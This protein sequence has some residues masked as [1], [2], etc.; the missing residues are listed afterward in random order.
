MLEWF[1]RQARVFQILLLFIPF[2]NWIIEICV[3]WSKFVETKSF[4]HFFM[5][6]LVT[7]PSGIAI[8]MIDAIWCLFF[9]HM[10]FAANPTEQQ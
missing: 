9:H 6:I 7:I 3:R 5:A 4:G 8:G 10:L 2:V 1:N